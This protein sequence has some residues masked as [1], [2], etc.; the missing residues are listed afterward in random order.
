MLIL[1]TEIEDAFTNALTICHAVQI[2][3]I[4]S[5]GGMFH[6]R[7]NKIFYL[8]FTRNSTSKKKKK[9]NIVL[10]VDKRQ[11][12]PLRFSSLS[13]ETKKG[14]KRRFSLHGIYRRLMTRAT[15]SIIHETRPRCPLTREK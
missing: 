5:R 7:N 11:L 4:S 10:A 13:K 8:I 15:P 12:S 9:R 14:R 1:A 3:R 2:I 6:Q